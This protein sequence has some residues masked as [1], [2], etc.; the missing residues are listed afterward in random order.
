[1][2]VQ[3]YLLQSIKEVDPQAKVWWISL[4]QHQRDLTKEAIDTLTS[5][6]IENDNEP[7]AG[8][9]LEN[10]ASLPDKVLDAMIA[11]I[12]NSG[13]PSVIDAALHAIGNR[14]LPDWDVDTL[15]STMTREP[16]NL[17]HDTAKMTLASIPHLSDN[18]LET[19]SNLII[20]DP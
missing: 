5:L 4:L 3:E 8:K 15:I 1:M 18:A 11:L 14:N 9:L 12:T 20:R 19:I 2:N 16:G 10:Q 6:F 7:D 17:V 13:N